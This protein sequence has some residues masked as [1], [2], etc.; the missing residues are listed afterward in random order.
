MM[1]STAYFYYLLR[2]GLSTVESLFLRVTVRVCDSVHLLDSDDIFDSVI[3][4]T[5]KVKYDASDS[6][7]RMSAGLE[8]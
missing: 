8:F 7:W 6:A 4:E 5:G 3:Y 2:A 1:C